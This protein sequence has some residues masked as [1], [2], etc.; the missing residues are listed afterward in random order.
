MLFLWETHLQ[1]Q[2]WLV[3]SCCSCKLTARA[4]ACTF[5]LWVQVIL[6]TKTHVQNCVRILPRACQHL[7]MCPVGCHLGVIA[8]R[9]P[10]VQSSAAGLAGVSCCIFCLRAR[11]SSGCSVLRGWRHR[12]ARG[13]VWA[14]V[15]VLPRPLSVLPWEHHAEHPPGCCRSGARVP[16]PAR[17]RKDGAAVWVLL[18]GQ[19]SRF[20]FR[21][22][23]RLLLCSWHIGSC[24]SSPCVR[25]RAG[26]CGAGVTDKGPRAVLQQEAGAGAL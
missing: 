9:L 18:P 6:A 4:L 23:P 12:R 17:G 21:F 20:G 10:G 24:V 3:F 11:V 2:T 8:R 7:S 19:R 15:R 14:F 5:S 22:S 26:L 25:L 16:L 13:D 1:D